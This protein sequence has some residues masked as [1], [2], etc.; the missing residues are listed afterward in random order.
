MRIPL[1]DNLKKPTQFLVFFGSFLLFFDLSYY[2]MATMP[3]IKDSMCVMGANLTVSNIVFSLA[4]GILFGVVASGLVSFLFSTS[5]RRRKI[6]TSSFSGLGA[7]L[8]SLTVFCLPCTLPAIS[9]FGISVSLNFFSSY[10]LF[11]R[12]AGFILL[13]VTA[14]LLNKKLEADCERCVI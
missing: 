2:F 9:L 13:L 1:L 10:N 4:M 8:G 11:L 7:L 3:G 6:M 14:F 5:K 12:V